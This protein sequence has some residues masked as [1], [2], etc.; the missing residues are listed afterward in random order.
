M[1]FVSKSQLRTCYGKN[2]KSDQSTWNCDEFLKK[3]ESVCC[4][5]EKKG[6][7]RSKTRC[8]KKG[9]RVKGSIKIGPKGGKFFIIEEKDKK[10]KVCTMKVYLPRK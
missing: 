10:G 3:T 1:P 4:L 9:E 5:P 6:T 2:N 8:M 7:S